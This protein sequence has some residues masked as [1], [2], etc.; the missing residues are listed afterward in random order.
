MNNYKNYKSGYIAIIGQPNAG[1]STLMNTLLDVKL[2]ITSPRPQ[3]TR[4]RVMGIFNEKNLQIVFLDTPGI[5]K[6]KYSLQ[7]EMMNY[8]NMAIV[9]ADL[10]VYILDGTTN[11]DKV[12]EDT[13]K[14]ANINPAGKP[15]IAAINKIDLISKSLLLPMIEKLNLV[16]PFESI[17]PIS[18]KNNDGLK[19]LI[20]SFCEY[21]PLHPPFYD[22]E[23]LTDQPERFFVAELIREQVFFQYQKE[24]PYSIEVLIIEF[25]ER[26]KGKDYIAAELYVERESQKAIVIGKKGEALKNLSHRA[27]KEIEKFLDKEIF[28]EVFVRVK[29]NWR[30]DEHL[31]KQFGY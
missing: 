18:A 6:P 3:T 1:K 5:L 19:E 8:V 11:Q 21:I 25:K 14:L 24:I 20:E 15:V 17:I 30:Q 12:F 28:L 2:S 23:M 10:L 7:K 22:P 16:Y 13:E 4:R 26:Q 27:R 31:L 29:K 9:D